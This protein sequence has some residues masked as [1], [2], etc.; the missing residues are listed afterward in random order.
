MVPIVKPA[1]SGDRRRN[2]TLLWSEARLCCARVEGQV[3]RVYG[4]TLG[5]L[6]TV[7]LLWSHTAQ[8]CGLNGKTFVHGI[9]DGAPWIVE[10]F[11]ENFG[12][13]G[14]Y[15][16]DFYHVTEYLAA[17]AL[18]IAGPKKA[19]YWLKKQKA[20]LLMGQTRKILRTLQTHREAPGPPEMETPVEDAC[21]YIGQR[22][23]H[24]HYSEARMANLPIGS[25]EVES[26]HRHVIQQRLKRA[27]AW[28][29]ETNA[30]AMLNLRVSRAN[31]CWIAYWSSN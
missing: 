3:R 24:L 14:R 17:A 10:K 28:W 23:E 25:G 30:Q 4:A 5:T 31:D 20:R 13:Q 22:L 29:K 2:K 6:E 27:G 18:K 12:S 16:I 7:S 19:A 8:V 1:Q 11:K 26:A 15:L 21:R 9:G